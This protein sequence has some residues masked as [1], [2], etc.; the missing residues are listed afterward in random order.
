MKK[1]FAIFLFISLFSFQES[2]AQN[3]KEVEKKTAQSQSV[4]VS[5]ILTLYSSQ[6][7]FDQILQPFGENLELYF[8]WTTDNNGSPVLQVN[9]PFTLIVLELKSE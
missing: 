3:S 8:D 7:P 1:L 6:L 9:V 5:E 2:V 4:G